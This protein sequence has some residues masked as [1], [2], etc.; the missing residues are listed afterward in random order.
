MKDLG[1]FWC[2]TQKASPAFW[3]AK[4]RE[5]WAKLVAFLRFRPERAVHP[6][7]GAGSIFVPYYRRMDDSIDRERTLALVVFSGFDECA[8]ISH[9]A[10]AKAP[11]AAGDAAAPRR[12]RVR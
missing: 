6:R 3:S 11:A 7:W 2:N 4:D 12:R 1:P 10:D 9:S 8:D 5:L